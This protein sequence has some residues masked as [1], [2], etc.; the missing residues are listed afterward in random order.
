MKNIVIQG[1]GFVGSAMAV[2]VASKFN[3]KNKPLFQVTGIDLPTR[4]GRARIDSIN[5]A[6]FPFK[7]NDRNLSDELIKAVERGNLKATIDKGVYSE[8]DVVVV[9]INC[10]LEKRD[11]QSKIAL[12]YF[13]NSILFE[14]VCSGE[15]RL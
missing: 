13:T 3:E 15:T 8:A 7:T 9:S 14:I 10:D 11:G 6:S 5:S 2:A 1:L 4:V 12:D